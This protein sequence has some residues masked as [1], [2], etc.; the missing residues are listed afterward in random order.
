MKARR[1]ALREAVGLLA[2]AAT[3]A[4]VS[5]GVEIARAGDAASP[6]RAE[7]PVSVD[8]LLESRVA[9]PRLAAPNAPSCESPGGALRDDALLEHQLR[10]LVRRAAA[11]QPHAPGSTEQ[12]IVLNG[13]GYN[14]RPTPLE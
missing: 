2:L 6:A 8:P 4:L 10:E 3:L 7:A 12:G 5:P 1:F 11:Q 13:R 14:Y 9:A